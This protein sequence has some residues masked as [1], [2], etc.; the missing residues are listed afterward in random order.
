MSDEK[1]E[2]GKL[3]LGA[4]G[5][6]EEILAQAV[7]AV[8]KGRDSLLRFADAVSEAAEEKAAIAEPELHLVTFFLDREEFGVPITQVREILR[9]GTITRIPEQ[10]PHIR[11]VTNVRGRVIPVVEIRSR[12][13]LPPVQVTAQSRILLVDSHARVLG[14]VVDAVSQVM[15]VKSQA[16]IPPPEEV[17]SVHADYI[18]GVARLEARLVIL[19]DLDKVLL[20]SPSSHSQA[21]LPQEKTP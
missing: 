8:P 7:A 4:F 6:A 9:V 21:S 20:L 10:P 3:S 17:L 13:G 19:L 5:T 2:A 1:Q 12:L 18:R 14:L 11:G 15:R 16:V